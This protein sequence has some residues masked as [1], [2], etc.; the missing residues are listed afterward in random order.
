MWKDIGVNA[1]V[2]FVDKYKTSTI[3]H[4]ANWSN[5]LRFSDPLGGMWSM[6]GEGTGI[7][8]DMWDAPERFNELGHLMLA[9]TDVDKRREE[10]REMMQI[11]DD[12][13]PGTILY[14]P[15]VI[16]ALRKDLT[17][18]YVVGRAL[19]LRADYLKLN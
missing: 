7:Q 11:W 1:Q 6:W 12:D 18:D 13:V 16:Y 9:E 3:E 4:L 2:K 5:G 15:D 14:C 19:N 10:Y 17:W 8:K